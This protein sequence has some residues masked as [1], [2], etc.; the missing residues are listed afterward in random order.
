M[1]SAVVVYLPN[2][3]LHNV[4]R[5][6]HE[7]KRWIAAIRRDEGAKYTIFCGSNFV[8]SQHLGPEELCI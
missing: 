7:R 4:L 2:L 1:E 3:S 6:D 8:C 5:D